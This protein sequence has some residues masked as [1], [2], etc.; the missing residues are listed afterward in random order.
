MLALQDFKCAID[1][2]ALNIDDAIFGHDTAWAD[3]GQIEEGAII[4]KVHN[5]NM[6][7]TTLDEY[8]LILE[9]RKQKEL[10]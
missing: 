6:G 7:T 4:R 10:T 2:Q 3:G 5:V 8:R 1:G 9:M